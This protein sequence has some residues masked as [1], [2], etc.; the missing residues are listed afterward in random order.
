MSS[1]VETNI[2]FDDPN[3]RPRYS[4]LI[5][6]FGLNNPTNLLQSTVPKNNNI[7]GK[8]NKAKTPRL[9][10]PYRKRELDR[11][12]DTYRT[13]GVVRNL[14]NKKWYFILGAH[15]SVSLD[16]NREFQNNDERSA[17]IQQVMTY[18]PY[19]RAM[20]CANEVLR[21]TNF[22]K[23][24]HAAGVQA[25]TYGRSC[26]EIVW[27][28]SSG[29]PVRFNVLNSKLLGDV[30][31]DPE[32]WEFLGVHYRDLPKHDDLL[33]AEN[34]IYIT[35]NDVH[36][37]PGSMYYGLSDLEPVIDGSETKR[38]IKQLDLKEM[39][40]SSWGGFG[41]IKFK[42]PNVTHQQIQEIV[43]SMKPGAWTATDQD[44]EIDVKQI[45]Q[46][47]PILLEIIDAMNLETARDLEV[48]SPLAGYEN[49][50]NYS[51]LV[52]TLIAWKES[53]LDAERKWVKDI[54]ESQLLNKI[55][56]RELQRQGIQIPESDYEDVIV[57]NTTVIPNEQPLNPLQPNGMITQN[58]QMIPPAKL[59][60]QIEDPNF[61]PHKERVETA[62]SLYSNDLISARKVLNEANMSDEIEETEARLREKALKAQQM[63]QFQMDTFRNNVIQT[64][65]LTNKK[66][67]I[68]GELENKLNELKGG[69]GNISSKG[70]DT[71]KQSY[72]PY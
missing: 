42:N 61:T 38:I 44:V 64:D 70:K 5:A 62:I 67:K 6:Q 7:F 11:F 28:P 37:S 2:R 32:T 31:V 63:Q 59:V 52:Q 17:Q 58:T 45:A 71:S 69:N 25:S 20:N 40:R 29:L 30:E 55:F 43:E 8:S 47:A 3:V 4:P 33:E 26:V 16:V 48:P 53:S 41:W 13:D 22:R 10:A 34:I 65:E 54:I 46:S 57:Q 35:R 36:I 24:I 12:E 18:E 50:Q 27:D 66:R 1:D 19:V 9:K 68:L 72:V 23:V 49:K 15:I 56:E 21:K 39:S 60:M 14:V 51:N